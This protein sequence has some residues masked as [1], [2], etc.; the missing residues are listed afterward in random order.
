MTKSLRRRAEKLNLLNLPKPILY[1]SA[2]RARTNGAVLKIY[3]TF[4]P[5]TAIVIRKY[6]E[7]LYW[8]TEMGISRASR[9]KEIFIL[10]S[11]INVFVEI[12]CRMSGMNVRKGSNHMLKINIYSDKKEYIKGIANAINSHFADGILA[13]INW[14]KMEKVF[15]IDRERSIASWNTLL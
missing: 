14:D 12:N 7:S 5:D 3:R 6:L 10:A 13:N 4:V 11:E 2:G 9:N 8:D 15:K 1:A